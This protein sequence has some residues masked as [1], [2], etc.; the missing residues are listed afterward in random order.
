M[1]PGEAVRHD[2]S[3]GRTAPT[4]CQERHCGTDTARVSAA[5]GRDPPN[6]APEG[7]TGSRSLAG[8]APSR[9]RR[10]Q[11]LLHSGDRCR[12][13]F[14]PHASHHRR[15]R[16]TSWRGGLG[17]SSR[18][19]QTSPRDEPSPTATAGPRAPDRSLS[20]PASSPRDAAA[21][22]RDARS[23]TD[24]AVR[25]RCRSGLGTGRIQV[26]G[27]RPRN[28]GPRRKVPPQLTSPRSSARQTWRFPATGLVPP[29]APAGRPGAPRSTHDRSSRFEPSP[30]ALTAPPRDGCLVNWG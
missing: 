9:I 3:S 12:D 18:T 16:P 10:G 22:A 24:R 23:S 25:P 11:R 4:S 28:D 14:G 8:R 6:L 5:N 7:S 29:T 21:A 1:R 20:T 19:R 2:G 13:A 30:Q 26:Q 17:G 15:S 27:P